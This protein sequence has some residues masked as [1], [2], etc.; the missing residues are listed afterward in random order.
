VNPP[1][2]SCSFVWAIYV[3]VLQQNASSKTQSKN[4]VEATIFWLNQQVQEGG[5]L[6]T[7]QTEE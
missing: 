7:H 4:Q 5:M 1:K 3:E 2:K 6:A